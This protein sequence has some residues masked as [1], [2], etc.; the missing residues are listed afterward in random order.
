MRF[1]WTE[2]R[3]AVA[4]LTRAALTRTARV[5]A[6]REAARSPSPDFPRDLHE[7]AAHAEEHA[8]SLCRTLDSFPEAPFTTQRLVELLLS[9]ETFC[10]TPEK[11]LR[12]AEKLL[13]VTGMV[14]PASPE[15]AL[16][17][18]ALAEKALTERRPRRDPVSAEQSAFV[19]ALVGATETRRA[20]D[21]LGF[22]ATEGSAHAAEVEKTF[23][24]GSISILG[25]PRALS[26]VS[27]ESD[28]PSTSEALVKMVGAFPAMSDSH[29]FPRGEAFHE[30]PFSESAE[31]LGGG[32]ERR[33]ERRERDEDLE[34][35]LERD[36]LDDRRDGTGGAELFVTAGA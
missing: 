23:P 18:K 24:S 30:R 8:S 6:N 2:V 11:L 28:D 15:K 16:A 29:G 13:A 14:S 21:G 34:R 36:F 3:I 4:A 32:F 26:D 25:R 10:A 5:A 35:A 22:S 1:P 33:G 27:R 12:A 20:G 31:A 9:P 17:E 7:A 19:C